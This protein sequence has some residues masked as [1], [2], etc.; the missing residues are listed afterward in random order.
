MS[1]LSDLMPAGAS[2]KTIE[3]TATAT[4]TSKAPVILNSAGTVT[5]VAETTT[6]YSEDL[7]QTK[8]YSGGTQNQQSYAVFNKAGDKILVLYNNV[9]VNQYL[10]A[11]IGTYSGETISWGTES[12]V[13]S[14]TCYGCGAWASPHDENE[15]VIANDHSAGRDLRTL[16]I[17]SGTSFSLGAI[18]TPS[19]FYEG[20]VA[21]D[22][23]TAGKIA[24]VS[25]DYNTGNG[26]CVIGTIVGGAITMSGT[27]NTYTSAAPSNPFFNQVCY[28]SDGNV[29]VTCQANGGGAA[30]E[31]RRGVVSGDT[32]TFDAYTN[33][34]SSAILINDQQTWSTNRCSFDTVVG[35]YLFVYGMAAGAKAKTGSLSGS[36]WTF[37]AVATQSGAD[38]HMNGIISSGMGMGLAQYQGGGSNYMIVCPITIDSSRVCT[39]GSETQINTNSNNSLNNLDLAQWAG[40]PTGF[41]LNAYVAET[42]SPDRAKVSFSQVA[43]SITTTNLT[44]TNFVGIADAAITS[45]ATFVVTVGGGKFVIDGVSQDTVSLQEGATYTFDQAAGTNSTHPLRFST[46]SDGTHGGGTEYTTG[47]TTNGTPGSAGAYTRIVVADSAPTL[48]YYCSAHS[49]MGGTANTP[50]FSATG[51]VVVQG[52]TVSDAN[53]ILPPVISFGSAAVYES[54]TTTYTAATFDS[55][56]NKV[57]IAYTDNG[58]SSYGTAIV[59]T[60]SGTSISY[61]TPVVFESATSSY[62]ATTFDSNENKVVIAY[63]D[64]ANSDYGTAIVGTVSG[65]AISFGTPVVFETANSSYVAA[66]FDSNLN[67]VVIAYQDGGNSSHGTAIVGTV[68]GTAISFGTAV[69]FEAASA[70]Y[71]SCAFDSNENKVVISYRDG[72]DADKGTAIV[73]TVSGTAISFGTAVVYST[74]ISVNSTVFDSNSNKIV[75]AY[76]H[77]GSSNYGTGI[78]GTVSGTAISFGTPTVFETADTSPISASFDSNSNSVAIAYSDAG[79]SYYGTAIVGTVSGTAISFGTAVVFETSDLSEYN[80]NVFDSNSNKVV[81]A[82]Q[83]D[84][85]S[86]YGT[87]IVGTIASGTFTIGSKYYVQNDGTITTVSSSVNAGLATSTTQLLLNGDS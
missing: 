49:G 25:S 34:E 13:D 87:G 20:S 12:I 29:I 50:A 56:A 23:V 15:F 67:K 72:G 40:S 42:P 52:G 48:Y 81:I 53:T 73:G 62:I 2:G 66:T 65:T 38:D 3:A 57:V 32:I 18:T 22:T 11:R 60:V 43:G 77:N 19:D 64:D 85:N 59:G 17:S 6:S 1:N 41:Y 76:R 75:I 35:D 74:D 26:V 7:D 10:R 28:N 33:A 16:T 86:D 55:N 78:V 14:D 21:Y 46:T 30:L 36:T 68:S 80:A 54:A 51:T 27:D 61:G 44:A 4:I 58:N 47:V 79:N 8:N 39:F 84:G 37:T 70:P 82:Y 69:V 63:R 24:V 5:E 71:I 45:D 31:V 9:T 83:D